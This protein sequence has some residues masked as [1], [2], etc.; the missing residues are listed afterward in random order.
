MPPQLY[1]L[2]KIATTSSQPTA[3][4]PALWSMEAR[5]KWDAWTELG[6]SGKF[7]G[8]EGREGA[9]GEYVEEATKLGFGGEGEEGVKGLGGERGKKEGKGMVSV[10]QMAAEEPEEG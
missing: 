3:P 8:E 9:R 6:A 5:A 4:R 2:Y 10:S 7:E 1:A